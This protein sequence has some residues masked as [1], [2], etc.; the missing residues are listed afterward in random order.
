MVIMVIGQNN[1][2]LI[3]KWKCYLTI[4]LSINYFQNKINFK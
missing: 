1:Q 3:L 2:R 4:V